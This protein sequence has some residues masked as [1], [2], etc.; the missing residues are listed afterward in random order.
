MPPE[1][2][3]RRR[4]VETAGHL[5][6]TRGYAATTLRD[7]VEAADA[8]WGSLH[9]YFPGGKEQ[10]AVE[11]LELRGA[12]IAEVITASFAATR[13]PASAMRRFFDDSIALLERAHFGIG[14]PV[15]AVVVETANDGSALRSTC[16]EI[17]GTWS[18]AF[19]EGLRGAGIDARR[20]RTLARLVIAQYEGA[21]LVARVE[22]DASA[23]RA[24]AKL[25]AELTDSATPARG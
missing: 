15:A 14:C 21:L 17:L 8:P 25:V 2:P 4:I 19:E 13:T 16:R 24:A 6:G 20:A 10:L 1:Q 5:F 9:H 22:Q 12:E 7:V 11:A 18:A 3:P 23:M